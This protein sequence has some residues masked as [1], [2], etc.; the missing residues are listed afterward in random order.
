MIGKA[1]FNRLLRDEEGATLT[2]FGFVAPILILLIMGIFDMAH[3]QYTSALM[4]GAMQDA[5]RDLTL[6]TAGSQQSNIDQRV[7]AAVSDVTPA[8]ATVTLEKLS[9]F[10]F[11]DIGEAEE[12]ADD[13]GDGVCNDNEVFVDVNE[14]GQWDADRGQ[15]GIG[16]ARD[17][18]LYTA[19]VTYPRLFPMYGL[20]GMPQDVTLRASTVLRNQ[21]F[22]EQDRS[23]STGNCP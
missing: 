11:S 12:F 22:D 8:T 4:N 14:N 18:V 9:H 5:A 1:I 16:G 13:N 19:V 2:E 21:P 17:A 15:T 6:E 3:S 10:D 20:A 23:T 7:I